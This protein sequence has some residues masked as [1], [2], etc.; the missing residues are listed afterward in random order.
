MAVVNGQLANQTTFNNAFMS[1]T[2]ATTQTV[3]KVALQNPDSGDSGPF[4][5]NT[6]KAINKAFEGVGAVSESDATINDYSSNNYV[7][8]GDNR[9]IAVGKLDT[10]LKSTQD[11]LDTAEVTIAVHDSDI[12]DLQGRVLDLEEN[13]MTI[14]G[15]KS[16]SGD[17]VVQGDFEVQ[18]TTTYINS[19]DLQVTDQNILVNKNGT[20]G[21]AEGA[22]LD[23]ERPSG[24]AGIRFDS[25]LASK[26]KIGLLANLLEVIVSGVAQT[27]VGVKDFLSGIKTDTIDESSSN[28][29]VT[30]DGV[31]IKDNLVDGRDV[32][33]DGATLDNHETRITTLEGQV[34]VQV[35]TEQAIA[36]GGTINSST[37]VKE[38]YRPIKSTGGAIVL[39]STPF[40]SGGGWENGTVMRL[41][42]T[43]DTDSVEMQS[44]D[45][46]FGA[47]L[48]GAIVFTKFVILEI[49]YDSTFNRWVEIK[50]NV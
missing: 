36:G 30:V 3:A 10:Q 27:I 39:S 15:N 1:R 20:D 18:G 5:T 50:R 28:A 37:T 41:I 21:S 23:V 29:G 24:N 40:G 42:G 12:L 46:A 47:I 25:T 31:L 6:Q 16:F 43:S 45:I 22:G 8:N 32:S 11:D 14:N 2:S 38:Q 9:K 33:V 48:N 19:T 44:N 49:M 4:I 7:N 26:F 34:G 13:D 17:I 35:Y